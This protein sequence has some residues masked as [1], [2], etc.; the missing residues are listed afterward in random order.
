[1]Q[2]GKSNLCKSGSQAYVNRVVTALSCGYASHGSDIRAGLDEV[3]SVVGDAI[4][5]MADI[6][7][8]TLGEARLDLGPCYG[9]SRFK[10]IE[11]GS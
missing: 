6:E 9:P 3:P 7:L 2:I 8:P 11:F 4:R 1:M 10:I 5:P